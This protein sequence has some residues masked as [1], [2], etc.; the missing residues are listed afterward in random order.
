MYVLIDRR[1]GLNR[2]QLDEKFST[3]RKAQQT[4]WLLMTFFA[5][6][7]YNRKAEILLTE[8]DVE[9]AAAISEDSTTPADLAQ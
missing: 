7:E 2:Q 5:S 4:I 3:L 9:L 1:R 8:I 6:P